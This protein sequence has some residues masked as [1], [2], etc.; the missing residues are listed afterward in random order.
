[1]ADLDNGYT[2]LANEILDKMAK[3]KLSPTQYRILFVVWRYTYGFQRKEHELSLSFLSAA[4]ECNQRSLQR[5]LKKLIDMNVIYELYPTQTRRLGFN[6][7]LDEW[8]IESIGETAN[9]ETTNGETANGETADESIGETTKGTIGETAKEERKKENTKESN[10]RREIFDYY[11][12]LGLI[13][14]K[15]FTKAMDDAIKTAMR[16]NGYTLEDCKALLYRH[17]QVTEK[18][19]DSEYPVRV[20]PLHEFFG[21]KAYNAKHLICD[22]Y[23]EGGK[24]YIEPEKPKPKKFDYDADLLARVR[25]Q[26]EVRDGA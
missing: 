2:R 11:L 4:T 20:R 1:M 12:S 8:R 15:R 3:T 18:T 21:Q 22:E 13:K 17:R 19:K 10:P 9:G 23:E 7:H 24:Y 26:Q 25:A 6:K 14:H 16:D 5:E